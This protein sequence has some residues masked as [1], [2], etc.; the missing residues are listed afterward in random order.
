MK[1]GFMCGMANNGICTID[2]IVN[3]VKAAEAMGFD[4]AWM[5]QVFSSDAITTM[6]IAGRETSRIRLGTAVTPSFPRH[7]TALA[8]QVLTTSAA[9]RGRFDL[10]LGLSHK[11]VM[12]DMFG[13]PYEKPA[14][15]MQEYLEVLMPLLRGESCAFDGQQYRVNA[16]LF[17][18][19]AKPTPVIVAALGPR[20]LSVA[21]RLA[22]GTTTWMTGPRTLENHT[23][24]RIRS[25]A[26][27]AGRPPPRIVASFP[28]AL[29][30]TVEQART[31]L[32][33]SLEMYGQLPSYRAMLDIEGLDHPADI[34]ILGDESTLRERIQHLRAIGVTDFNAFCFAVDEGAAA[35]TQA[36]LASEKASFA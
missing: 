35:R 31:R 17:V 26:E 14:R 12:E 6:A 36:F 8:I 29:T 10:G 20:M 33:K 7:P 11:I 2:Q 25:A 28:I 9:S 16:R 23:I 21:G 22:D 5:A 30:N 24:P 32:S 18:P 27:A 15:H 19:D 13:I 4:Q 3:E 1:L 34:A